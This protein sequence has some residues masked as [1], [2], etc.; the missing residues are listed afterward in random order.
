MGTVPRALTVTVVAG[1]I[2][3]PAVGAAT[4]AQRLGADRRAAVAAADALL[5]G[6]VLPADARPRASE[7]S[8]DAHQLARPLELFFYAA[9][10]DRHAFWTTGAAPAAV[11]A[12]VGAHVPPG[13]RSTGSGS[14]SGNEST[15]V[16]VSYALPIVDPSALGPRALII[17][18]VTLPGGITGVRAD[19]VVRYLAPRLP[20][21]RVPR[22][23]RLLDIRTV[24]G[25]R[26]LRSL[27]VTRISQVR[28]VAAVVDGLPFA[29]G[30]KGIAL[31]CPF[32]P[33]APVVTFT[34]RAAATRP[35]LAAVTE[36]ADAPAGASPC[37][38]TTLT[39]RGRR[40][41][42][43]LEGGVL[44]Q[45]AGAILGVTLT[46]TLTPTGSVTQARS[47]SRGA[48]H[49]RAAAAR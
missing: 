41:A 3:A 18:A 27:T 5:N 4:P 22:A 10:V 37:T 34:F 45:R 31:P 8:R 47:A 46:S 39:I 30:L 24:F 36:L 1:L 23:A 9:E 29:R 49:R 44:L 32:I 14:S 16:F 40:E 21:Q 7:P 35:A 11:I 28:G 17:D 48:P 38:L 43:L 2:S 12:S 20:A 15:S 33:A 42:P 25:S 26:V 13:A 6:V 19:A